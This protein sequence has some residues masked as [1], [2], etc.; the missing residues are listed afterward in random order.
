[1]VRNG[2]VSVRGQSAADGM[3]NESNHV[4]FKFQ[5]H[6]APAQNSNVKSKTASQTR[7]YF[8]R[9]CALRIYNIT[10]PKVPK[11]PTFAHTCKQQLTLLRSEFSGSARARALCVHSR[12]DGT[13]TNPVAPQCATAPPS[14]SGYI[15]RTGQIICQSQ[16]TPQGA[17]GGGGG[18]I[19][20]DASTKLRMTLRRL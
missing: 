7:P 18:G 19:V 13:Q 20:A 16:R 8:T 17:A 5:A 15:Q 10:L 4:W 6:C 9:G 3:R 14:L 11:G 1:M 2:L 12:R